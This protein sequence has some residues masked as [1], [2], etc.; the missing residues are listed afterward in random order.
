MTLSFWSLQAD[1]WNNHE[2]DSYG[3]ISLTAKSKNDD[4]E[5]LYNMSSVISR[6][7]SFE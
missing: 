3:N 4:A 7:K 1:L 2:R 6:Q 5:G